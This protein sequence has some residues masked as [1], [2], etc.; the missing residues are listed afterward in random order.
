[1]GQKLL[2]QESNLA[3]AKVVDEE[4]GLFLWLYDPCSDKTA[5]WMDIWTTESSG[6]VADTTTLF[7]SSCLFPLECALLDDT[8]CS[9]Q[10]LT[11]SKLCCIA[12]YSFRNSFSAVH[13]EVKCGD[14]WRNK[15]FILGHASSKKHDFTY[16]IATN[17]DIS[18]LILIFRRYLKLEIN[19][20]FRSFTSL[21]YILMKCHKIRRV[22]LFID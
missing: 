21:S 12:I 14:S 3:I 20:S 2:L 11:K 18:D 10:N 8:S 6:M 7:C 1:M 9:Y 19:Q 5:C 22:F 16:F 15:I 4:R 17:E 13:T